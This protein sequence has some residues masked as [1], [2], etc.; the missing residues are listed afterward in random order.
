MDWQ[1]RD[2]YGGIAE[3]LRRLGARSAAFAANCN[4]SLAAQVFPGT[5][6]TVWFESI[7]CLRQFTVI[8]ADILIIPIFHAESFG[9]NA[10]LD[11]T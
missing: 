11:K 6:C 3:N 10:Q 1:D 8:Q 4:G 7:I 2:K 5:N 9:D